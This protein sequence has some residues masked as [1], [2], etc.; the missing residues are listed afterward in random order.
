MSTLEQ[1]FKTLEVSV[2]QLLKFAESQTIES[3]TNMQKQT[4]ES[5]GPQHMQ[6]STSESQNGPEHG[7][8]VTAESRFIEPV[9]NSFK[10]ARSVKTQTQADCSAI[11]AVNT[12]SYEMRTAESQT[13][14]LLLPYTKA[15]PVDDI[16]IGTDGKEHGVRNPASHHL[17]EPFVK[18]MQHLSLAAMAHE[19]ANS[20]HEGQCPP[21]LHVDA[22]LVKFMASC[23]PNLPARCC[24]LSQA[25]SWATWACRFW[26]PHR[27]LTGTVSSWLC[28]RRQAPWALS[29]RQQNLSWFST[30]SLS[31]SR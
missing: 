24:P 23:W 6:Q 30:R 4:I 31:T 22:L 1:I 28:P 20:K 8:T 26:R 5:H 2:T 29:W 19:V 17:D 25:A 12:Q 27:S 18:G 9:P 14:A 15:Y 3:P 16:F 10:Q 13:T 7:H 21:S 11:V